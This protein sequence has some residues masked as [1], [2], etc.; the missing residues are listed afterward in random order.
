MADL[1]QK[2]EAQEKTDMKVKLDVVQLLMF[3]MQ[4]KICAA[5]RCEFIVMS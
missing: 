5:V 3:S 1:E 4:L 2:L